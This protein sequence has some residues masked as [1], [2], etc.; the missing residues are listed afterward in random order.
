MS[1]FRALNALLRNTAV[2]TVVR[3]GSKTHVI[4]STA[5]AEIEDRVSLEV[6]Q[7]MDPEGTAVPYLIPGFTDAGAFSRWGTPYYGFSPIRFPVSPAVSFSE[8]YHGENERIPVEGFK[9]GLQA[10]YRVVVEGC[11]A[12]PSAVR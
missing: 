6:M 1:G 7:S 5:V 3:A 11:G 2:P 9:Q 8:L 10:L 12:Q 4:P